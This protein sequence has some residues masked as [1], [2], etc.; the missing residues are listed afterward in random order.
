V[1]VGM[2]EHDVCQWRLQHHMVR[3][4][5]V[6]T[7]SVLKIENYAIFIQVICLFYENWKIIITWL[8]RQMFWHLMNTC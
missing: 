7:T 5:M 3:S 4:N 8:W 2:N 1:K 6:A